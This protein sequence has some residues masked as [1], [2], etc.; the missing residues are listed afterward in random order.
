MQ[1][2]P[3]TAWSD[4]QTLLKSSCYQ[5]YYVLLCSSNFLHCC[6]EQFERSLLKVSSEIALGTSLLIGPSHNVKHTKLDLILPQKL[7]H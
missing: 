5:V 2:G 1:K 6:Q 4:W 3:T 7:V